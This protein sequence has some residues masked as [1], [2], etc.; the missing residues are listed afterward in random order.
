MRGNAYDC[1]PLNIQLQHK[2]NHGIKVVEGK[3]GERSSD[4]KLR[5]IQEHLADII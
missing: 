1:A 5:Y 3:G 2:E 4:T